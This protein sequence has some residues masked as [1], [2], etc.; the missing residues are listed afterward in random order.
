MKDKNVIVDIIKAALP[1]VTAVIMLN[2]AK[3]RNKKSKSKPRDKMLDAVNKQVVRHNDQ[4][5]YDA[6]FYDIVKSNDLD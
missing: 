3:Q 2:E 1:V 6:L 5:I 4:I